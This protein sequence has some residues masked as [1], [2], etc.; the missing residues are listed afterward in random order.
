MNSVLRVF[1]KTG[2]RIDIPAIKGEDGYSPVKGVDYYTDDE[3]AEICN[4]VFAMLPA[5]EMVATLDD[6]STTTY[7]IYG[8]AVTE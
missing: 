4:E 6:G 8:G 1:D 2:K 3:K 7:R 5:L